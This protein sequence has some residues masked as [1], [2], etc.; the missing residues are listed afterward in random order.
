MVINSIKLLTPEVGQGTP[1]IYELDFCKNMDLQAS[2]QKSYENDIIFPATTQ[3][4]SN[5]TGCRVN[6]VSQPIPYELPSGKYKLKIVFTYKVNPIR[7]IVVTQ[8]TDYFYVT[9][10]N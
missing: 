5:P 7:D 1:L 6:K 8:Y 3:L 4:A 9:E 2:V 10:R